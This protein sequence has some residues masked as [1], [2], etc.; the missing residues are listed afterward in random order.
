MH[1][2]DIIYRS[3]LICKKRLVSSRDVQRQNPII[4][5]INLCPKGFP[6]DICA[7][8]FQPLGLKYTIFPSHLVS[9]SSEQFT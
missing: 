3:S 6:S 4:L 9:L 1:P 5:L 2:K 7:S 8:A